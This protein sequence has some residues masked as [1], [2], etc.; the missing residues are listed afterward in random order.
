MGVDGPEDAETVDNG[1]IDQFIRKP[2]YDFK[3]QQHP[4]Q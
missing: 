3:S 2:I 1:R 4:E